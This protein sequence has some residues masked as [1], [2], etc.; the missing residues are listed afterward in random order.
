[1]LASFCHS[2]DLHDNQWYQPNW[3]AKYFGGTK[4]STIFNEYF[5]ILEMVQETD[6]VKTVVEWEVCDRG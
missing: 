6:T 5:H 3:D 2:N 4:I 1:M